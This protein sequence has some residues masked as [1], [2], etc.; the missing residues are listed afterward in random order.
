MLKQDKQTNKDISHDSWD[1]ATE[2]YGGWGHC[3]F[4]IM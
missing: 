4:S 2:T 1:A 3:E